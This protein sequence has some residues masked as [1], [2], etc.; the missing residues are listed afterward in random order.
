ML[1]NIWHLP[2]ELVISDIDAIKQSATDNFLE[3]PELTIDCSELE[4]IDTIGM[5]FLLVF[6]LKRTK[7]NNKTLWQNLSETLLLSIEQLGIDKN[8]L[9][10]T[11]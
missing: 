11:S 6:V 7:N 10:I 4:R 1:N 5:Q 9:A 2:N 3:S 8:N